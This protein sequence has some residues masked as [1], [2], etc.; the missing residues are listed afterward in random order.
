[1]GIEVDVCMWY[2]MLQ[3]LIVVLFVICVV[4][5]LG[6]LI[7]WGMYCVFGVE[8]SDFGQVVVKVVQGYLGFLVGEQFVLV[9][10]VLVL[11]GYMRSEL[12]MIVSSVR[13]VLE[14]IV[15]GSMEI[16]LGNVDLSQWIEE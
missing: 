11:F 7:V 16:V 13:D 10:S 6:I 1:M 2:E 4:V 3:F 12:V 5:I 15:N 9:G 14:F 8:F